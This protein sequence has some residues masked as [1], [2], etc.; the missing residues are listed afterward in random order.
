MVTRFL[1]TARSF[2]NNNIYG[3]RSKEELQLDSLPFAMIASGNGKRQE[4]VPPEGRCFCQ[5]V[6]FASEFDF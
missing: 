3:T 5:A 4:K 2:A 1:A 6:L